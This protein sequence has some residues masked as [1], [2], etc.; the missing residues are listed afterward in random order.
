MWGMTRPLPAQNPAS[1]RE[2]VWT[3]VAAGLIALVPIADLFVPDN[4]HLAHTLVLPVA[5]I[6]VFVG[7]RRATFTAVLA[8]LALVAAGAERMT[9]ISESVLVQL[10]CLM[11]LSALLVAVSH[12][13]DRRRQE[14]VGLRRVSEAVLRPLPQ[15]AG[16]VSIASAYRAAEIG[17]P[18][19]GDLYAVARTADSTRLLIGD[20]RG[21][22]AAS[23]A[24]TELVL[25]AFRA[26]AHRQ[27]PLPELVASLEGSVRWGLNEPG[28]AA[29]GDAAERFV[30]AAV[31][32]IPD[33]EPYVHVVSCG[34][35]P[36]L[37]FHEGSVTALDATDPAPPLGLGALADGGYTPTTFPFEPGDRLLVYTDG[38]TEARD[39]KGEF[40]PLLERAAAWTGHLPDA[41]VR[42]VTSELRA[43]AA[44][45]LNDD[46]AVVALRRDEPR[47]AVVPE[48][49]AVTG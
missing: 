49:V 42:A 1:S 22:G 4:V 23:V 14:L 36:P 15:R 29:A 16:P 2:H 31:V 38:V 26:A 13:L 6:A 33:D 9:L 46:M 44:A 32:E 24:D 48:A 7:P 37:L 27:S 5:L 43:H 20:V 8:V 40:Y 18:V 34:H 35:L 47:P 25:G 30:T 3:A 11:L 41:M 12:M 10:L 45:G 28:D 19:G 17:S 21:K 39:G